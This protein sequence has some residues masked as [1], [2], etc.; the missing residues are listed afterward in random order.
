MSRYGTKWIQIPGTNCSCREIFIS[1]FQLLP[2]TTSMVLP[3]H[4]NFLIWCEGRHGGHDEEFRLVSEERLNIEQIFNLHFTLLLNRLSFFKKSPRS[5]S[6]FFLS[7]L[8]NYRSKGK[9]TRYTYQAAHILEQLSFYCVRIKKGI[10]I[11]KERK[12]QSA[13]YAF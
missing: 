11:A 8:K 6:Q 13:F 9:K 3:K 4:Q 1:S 12:T 7:L 2:G 5:L 10:A